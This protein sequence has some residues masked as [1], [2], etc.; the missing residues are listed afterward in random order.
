MKNLLRSIDFF[1]KPFN[2]TI[3]NYYKYKTTFGGIMSI[4]CSIMIMIFGI[5]FGRDFIYK[6]TPIIIEEKVHP[7]TY[8]NPFKLTQDN[9]IIPWKISSDL[10]QFLNIENKLFITIIYNE[11][12]LNSTGLYLKKHKKVPYSKCNKNNTKFKELSPNL[13][14]EEWNCFDWENDNYTFGGFWD[15]SYVNNFELYISFCKDA[16][17]FNL[18]NTCADFEIVNKLLNQGSNIY[19]E[20]MLPEVFF[21]PESLKEPL[22]LSFRNYYSHLNL[23]SW[24]KEYLFFSETILLDDMGW[25]TRDIKEH[26]LNGLINQN[27][28]F[29]FFDEKNYG[30]YGYSSQLYHIYFYSSK[31]YQKYSRSFMKI[32]DLASIL[33]GLIKIFILIGDYITV[34]PNDVS[35]IN[36]LFRE[37]FDF[38]TDRN[39]WNNRPLQRPLKNQFETSKIMNQI[40]DN[41]SIKS[42]RASFSINSNRLKSQ[43]ALFSINIPKAKNRQFDTGKFKIDDINISNNSSCKE[44]KIVLPNLIRSKKDFGLFFYLK[45]FFKVYIRKNK[46][47]YNAYDIA[48]KYFY[49][50][51]DVLYYLKN[52]IILDAIKNVL[53]N[54]FQIQALNYIKIPNLASK[55]DLSSLK[56][57]LNYK[58]E[59][60]S[61]EI[62]NYF[63]NKIKTNSI[64]E[65]DSRILKIIYAEENN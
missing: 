43:K 63:E 33:G 25:I 31:S 61:N 44:I 27:S 36:K 46:I 39:F 1:G 62:C 17:P 24:K 51:L 12:Q 4:T 42:H 60:F 19:F 2:F 3:L 48:T 47:K 22:G 26:Q 53:F 21:R 45:R 10:E 64:E 52:L 18:N 8:L 65:N 29:S 50:R 35:Q 59:D 5:I 30:K 38:S 13:K 14:I 37:F 16:R 15:G 56:K 20:M 41:K 34:I 7:V 6:K 54:K 55:M 57:Q 11:F 32:Q 28:D 40:I 23:N 49:Q 9:F 58:K